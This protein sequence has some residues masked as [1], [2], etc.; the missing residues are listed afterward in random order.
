MERSLFDLTGM[1]AIVTGASRGIGR[2]I[3][4]RMAQQ[5]AKV[6]VSSRKI[7]ACQ[8]VVDGIV[9]RGGEAIA[10]ACNI[11]RKPE[12]QALVDA[13]LAKW[14]RIDSLV[15]NAAINPHFGPAIDM[16]DEAFDK[17]MAS[18]VK[19][20]LWLAHMALPGMAAQGGGSVIIVSSIGGLRG[21]PV[22]GGYGISKAADMQLARNLAVEWGPRNIRANCI[23]PGL[24]R[25]DFARALWEN[26]E[27]Y[28]KR[29]RDT[30]L[31]R[32]GEPD[33]IAG[34][35]VFLASRAGSFMTGQTIVID[36]GIMAG[37]PMVG[38]D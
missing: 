28:R 16:P 34:A 12:L 11:G 15:C 9:A 27:I 18:N 38:E 23:A 37:P 19:S 6:V 4:E 21:S 29:T 17:I 30:P 20:N 8:E 24:V 36:G 14:G 10:V 13:T 26:P 35:A 3:A 7:D 2:A 22:L 25:T 31:Q 5:G 33:E 32:I 1:V